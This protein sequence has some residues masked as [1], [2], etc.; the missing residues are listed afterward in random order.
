MVCDGAIACG[1]PDAATVAR[2]S[3]PVAG[4][5]SHTSQACIAYHFTDT[6]QKGGNTNTDFDGDT[7]LHADTNADTD[8]NGDL[9]TASRNRNGIAEP[10]IENVAYP[11]LMFR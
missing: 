4:A 2:H 6:T 5:D 10:D 7:N 11:S 3:N 9:R 1:V 8:A